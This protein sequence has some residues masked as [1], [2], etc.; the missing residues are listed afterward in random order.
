MSDYTRGDPSPPASG[1]QIAPPAEP[2]PPLVEGC[3]TTCWQWS[4]ADTKHDCPGLRP[5]PE[6]DR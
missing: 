6:R 2:T 3:C 1:S 5:D 4:P